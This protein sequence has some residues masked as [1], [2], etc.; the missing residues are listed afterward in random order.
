MQGCHQKQA[1]ASMSGRSQKLDRFTPLLT[2]IRQGLGVHWEFYEE[3][4]IEILEAATQHRDTT[5][6]FEQV[7]RLIGGIDEVKFSHE[8]VLFH[9]HDMG[10]RMSEQ[11]SWA[12]GYTC[13]DPS[14]TLSPT[15]EQIHSSSIYEDTSWAPSATIMSA[16]HTSRPPQP[17]L[18]VHAAPQVP[19]SPNNREGRSEQQQ[20]HL[21]PHRTSPFDF[22]TDQLP[23]LTFPHCSSNQ[24]VTITGSK[25]LRLSPLKPQSLDPVFFS[26]P[27]F[28][29]RVAG[30]FGQTIRPRSDLQKRADFG[31]TQRPDGVLL[32]DPECVPYG[33]EQDDLEAWMV[34]P[35]DSEDGED[36]KVKSYDPVPP[37][38]PPWVN[39]YDL[40]L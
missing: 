18:P 11:Q 40:E 25:P 27:M 26:D 31:N 12:G 35:K 32:L 2:D 33:P 9:L 6:W 34:K 28:K 16:N 1:K 22:S 24:N 4:I 37:T 30:L 20:P 13:K 38:W 23:K 29:E 17:A 5:A 7:Q 36:G 8:G 10:I 19:P 39:R 21:L 3:C 15:F 14:L